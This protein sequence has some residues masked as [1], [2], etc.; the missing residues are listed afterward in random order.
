MLLTME[1]YRIRARKVLPRFVF[2]FVDGGAEHETCLRANQDDFERIRLTPRVLRNTCAVDSTVEIYGSAWRLPF[3]LAPTGLNGVVRPGGDGMLA[4]AA[5]E[6][7]VPFVLST[8]SNQ[9]A[10]D[11]RA[12]AG[13]GEQ[14]L[15]LYVMQDR[16]LAEQLVRRARAAGYRALVLTA[17]VP[18]GGRRWRDVRNGFSMP[19]RITPR[20]AWDVAR[21]PGWA[22]RMLR[23]GPPRFV[24]L[25]E[26]ADESLSME[27]Q[28]SLLARSMDRSLTWDSLRW[29]R[30]L[31][32]GP[33]LLKG[34]L[35]REDAALAVRHGVDGLIV[36]NHGGRQ[37]D[38]APSSISVLPGIVD[39]VAD[40]I[41]VFLDSGVRSGADIVRAQTLGARA[42]FIG[43]PALYGL[44][45]GGAR[46]VVDVMRLLAEDYERTMILSGSAGVCQ[47]R[48]FCEPAAQPVQSIG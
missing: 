40:R 10:E 33:L 7:G 18:V 26:R 22:L 16:R 32:G 3:A 31:W 30:S 12:I 42:V 27:V 20:I 21:R 5:A 46:G 15:Q 41:P 6:M 47:A 45:C 44:A 19:F 13:G 17:D 36:S 8:A 38:A 9:R 29:L 24:N 48:A 28:A 1:D 2:E 4:R 14:W 43:R 35:H 34:V 37:L 39:A 25:A 11:V 23:G